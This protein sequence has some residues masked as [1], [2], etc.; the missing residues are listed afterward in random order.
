MLTR[1]LGIPE[2]TSK[3]VVGTTATVLGI[4]INTVLLQA[5]L[6]P[7]KLSKALDLTQAALS[8]QKLSLQ[9]VE[10]LTGY[11]T[12]CSAVVF[13]RNLFLR[14]LWTFV[15]RIRAQHSHFKTRIPALVREDLL[16]WNELLP[17]FNGILLLQKNRPRINLYT[18]ASK[19]GL[20][21]YYSIL[22]RP[23]Q[24]NAFAI[25]NTTDERKAHINYLET[26]AVEAAFILWA[27]RWRGKRVVIHTDNSA[28]FQ[29]LTSHKQRGIG[30]YPLRHILLLA[31]IHDVILDPQWIAGKTN[32]IADSLSRFNWD[33]LANLCPTWQFPFHVT[34]FPTSSRAQWE[35][36]HTTGQSSSIL[37]FLQRH[38][39]RT[40]Q[41]SR[42]TPPLSPLLFQGE[43]HG[44]LS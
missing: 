20:G 28:T 26:R 34:L 16:W 17:Q 19:A 25:R 5:R 18:D 38:D 36:Q 42:A 27:H 30:F 12:W 41:P 29:G 1:I 23:L 43:R 24:S 13:I 4:T 35:H 14:H 11:L 31:T 6:S 33:K 10:S 9:K 15:A 7:E 32:E 8:K 22:S 3:D 21:G 2:N 39:L 40:T 37:G 44:Q